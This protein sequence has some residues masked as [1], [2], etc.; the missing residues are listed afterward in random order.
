M[1]LPQKTHELKT[2]P[3]Y[4]LAIWA[5]RKNFEIRL[6][7]RDFKVGDVLTLREYDPTL[8]KFTGRVVQRGVIYITDFP[9]GL[10]P[11]YVALGLRKL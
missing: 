5:H 7:D 6:N 9:D 10:K 11:G 1:N 2:W 4:F 8:D 3:E